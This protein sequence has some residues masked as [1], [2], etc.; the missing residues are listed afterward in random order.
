MTI[1]VGIADPDRS[2]SIGPLPAAEERSLK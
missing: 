1:T 2:R